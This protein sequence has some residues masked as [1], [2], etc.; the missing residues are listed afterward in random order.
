M[1]TLF[2]HS[3]YRINVADDSPESP[4]HPHG[5]G[6]E[7]PNQLEDPEVMSN[8]VEEMLNWQDSDSDSLPD[9]PEID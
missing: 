6:P 2:S 3:N 7:Y 8:Y 5:L 1:N 4:M 9:L